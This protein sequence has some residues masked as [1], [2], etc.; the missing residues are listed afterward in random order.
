MSHRLAGV[1]RQNAIPFRAASAFPH[2][3]RSALLNTVHLHNALLSCACPLPCQVGW[4]ALMQARGYPVTD[5]D[6]RL[7]MRLPAR[8]HSRERAQLRGRLFL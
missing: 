6:Q 7:R 5:F 3:D 4:T 2:E 8:P 1:D